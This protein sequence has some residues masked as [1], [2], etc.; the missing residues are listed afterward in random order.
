M[1]YDYFM[2]LI[3]NTFF[4]AGSA[5]GPVYAYDTIAQSSYESINVVVQRPDYGWECVDTY[6]A[7]AQSNRGGTI[8]GSATVTTRGQLITVVPLSTYSI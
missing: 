8:S 2:V 7:I 4:F 1:I 3:I 6:T 5:S